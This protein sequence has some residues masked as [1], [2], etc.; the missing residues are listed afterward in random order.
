[1]RGDVKSLVPSEVIC[2]HLPVNEPSHGGS[3]LS[4]DQLASPV[5]GPP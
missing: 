1:V 4:V 5:V 3:A 2:F